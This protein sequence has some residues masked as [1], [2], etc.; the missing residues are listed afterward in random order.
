MA[1]GD[2]HKFGAKIQALNM[3]ER[4]G[5]ALCACRSHGSHWPGFG[6]GEQFFYLPKKESPKPVPERNSVRGCLWRNEVSGTLQ[7]K[8]CLNTPTVQLLFYHESGQIWDFGVQYVIIHHETSLINIISITIRVSLR[9]KFFESAAG[10]GTYPHCLNHETKAMTI[11][12]GF[13]S[14]SF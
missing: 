7:Q 14:T 13:L 10:Y 11:H 3:D 8:L 4:V 5:A 2:R 1:P 12:L 9:F 6:L